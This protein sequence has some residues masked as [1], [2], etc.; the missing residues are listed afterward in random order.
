M[1]DI[2]FKPGDEIEW[3]D[4]KGERCRG[5]VFCTDD[6]ELYVRL[7]DAAGSLIDRDCD[8]TLISVPP[9]AKIASAV[10]RLVETLPEIFHPS[11]LINCTDGARKDPEAVYCGLFKVVVKEQRF[12]KGEATRD[13]DLTIQHTVVPETHVETWSKLVRDAA[14]DLDQTNR[15]RPLDARDLPEDVY[16]TADKQRLCRECFRAWVLQSAYPEEPGRHTPEELKQFVF[17]FVDGKVFTDRHLPAGGDT[18]MAGMVFMTLMLMPPPPKD[19]IEKVACIYEHLSKAGPRSVNGMP[20]FMSHRF[21][22]KDDWERVV[23]HIQAEL[24]RRE[25]LE[26]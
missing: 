15:T 4:K 20:M 12:E 22:H 18:N 2:D 17:D 16:A 7:Y 9:D 8:A 21:M 19:Y 26:L 3:L 1:N 25:Q 10:D 11:P 6:G 14:Y 24:E 5:R 13:L 23:P